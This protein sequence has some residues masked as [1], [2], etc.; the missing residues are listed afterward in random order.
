VVVTCDTVGTSIT[1][2][3]GGNNWVHGYMRYENHDTNSHGIHR[4]TSDGTG[5]DP[6]IG[7]S[8]WGIAANIGLGRI[9]QR[10]DCRTQHNYIF[11]Y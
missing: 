1:R 5:I 4:R 7:L 9:C 10:N 8:D 11:A 6:E 3:I 2:F